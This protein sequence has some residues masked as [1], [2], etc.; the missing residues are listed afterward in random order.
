MFFFKKLL[1]VMLWPLW[2]AAVAGPIVVDESLLLSKDRHLINDVPFSVSDQMLNVVIE[3]PAGTSQKWEVDK[4]SGQIEWEK[5]KG[6]YRVIDFLSYPGNYGFI[7]QTY[8]S[9]AMGGD[10]DPLDVLVLGESLPRG[11]VV[12][13][14]ILGSL[15]LL[16]GGEI[17]DKYIAIPLNSTLFEK[18][19]D[20]DD[21]LIKYPGSIEIVR[22]WFEGYKKPGKIQFM[23]YSARKRAMKNIHLSHAEWI[24]AFRPRS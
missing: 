16:D 4:I 5:R 3:I 10:G 1:L 24:K 12:E 7:P 17:D 13:V 20:L 9:I 2:A 11:T 6:K 14:R 8:Q 15:K 19:K 21:A 23:G 22:T 18:V